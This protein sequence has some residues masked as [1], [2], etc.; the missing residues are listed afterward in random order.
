[1]AKKYLDDTGL[2]VLWDKIKSYVTNSIKVTGVKGDKESS[3]RTGNVNLTPA[4]IG[5]A[6]EEHTHIPV[7][8][9]PTQTKSY[10]GV[11]CTAN[12]DPAGYLYFGTA[13]PDDYYKPWHLKFIAKMKIANRADGYAVYEFD[14]YGIRNTYTAYC[15]FNRVN[16]SSYRPIYQYAVFP[17]NKTGIDNGYGFC[18]GFRFQSA[19][20][21][22]NATYAR[23]IDIEIYITENCTFTFFDSMVV[24]SS[25]AGTPVYNAATTYY[26][27][28]QTFDGTTNGINITGDRNTYLAYSAYRYYYHPTVGAN[29]IKQYGLYMKDG[30]GKYQ[31]FTITYGTGTTKTK[32]PVG[33]NL[34]EGVIYYHNSGTNYTLNQRVP[35]GTAYWKNVGIDFR[36]SSNCGSTLTNEEYLY[37]VGTVNKTDN[38]F[39]LDDIWWTQSLPTTEDNKIYIPIGYVYQNGYNVEFWGTQ[40]PLYFKNGRIQ[41]YLG[42]RDDIYWQYNSTTESIDIVFPS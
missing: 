25:V 37:I 20:S 31:S 41:E 2:G 4:N 34:N 5:A 28:R 27:K 26:E 13:L 39:Y 22:A 17:A 10:T 35:T 29:G 7:D 6:E 14:Y 32:N 15:C 12:A 40:K 1:M 33:F 3:Y 23:D 16:N 38:L 8:I 36:Y 21:P 24:E 9:I 19:D 18:Y 30:D 42:Y 11:Y